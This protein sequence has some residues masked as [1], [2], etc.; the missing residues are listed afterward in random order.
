MVL[1]KVVKVCWLFH[2]IFGKHFIAVIAVMKKN[3]LFNSLSVVLMALLFF[4][5]NQG[6]KGDGAEQS[7][8]EPI[9]E[10][11]EGMKWIAGGEFMMGTNDES[12]YSH[13]GPAHPV[14]VK[15]FYIDETEVTNIEFKRFVEAT[16]YRT[17]AE[18]AP[19]W[20]ELK[21][22]LPPETPRP[23]APFKPGSLVFV[24]PTEIVESFQ[25]YSQWWHWVE[26]ANWQHPEG[27]ESNLEQRWNHPVVQV[28][29][30]DAVAYCT[31][32]KKRL[33]TEAEWE[34]ASRGGKE[35]QVY[36]WG[37]EFKVNG[38]FMA[39][40][41]Q[42]SF[43]NRNTV[44]DGFV[45]TSPIKTFPASPYGLFD[46]IGN[47]WEWTTDRYDFNYYKEVSNQGKVSNPIGSTVCFDPNEPYAIKYVT[48]GGSF[49]CAD[50]YCS[51]FRTTARQGTAF[52]SGSSNVGF[53]C[54]RD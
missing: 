43:P 29:Y 49:L 36:S 18:M 54:V 8:P 17:T 12:A 31:W 9:A 51:N 21:K 34:F 45:N 37:N 24:E 4:N 46:M 10:V 15:G 3:F 1:N 27:P 2:E 13:E 28:S 22:Q 42:G 7:S 44:E 16:G 32:A 25:D 6:R 48:R 40:T 11:S 39:N 38:K 50:N 53:R 26:G 23:D 47:V 5:C 20:E 52:D 33:P 30:N 41:F 35:N 19:Q 14:V